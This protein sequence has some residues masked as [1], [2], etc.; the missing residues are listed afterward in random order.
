MSPLTGLKNMSWLGALRERRTPS[1]YAAG[2]LPPRGYR[3]GSYGSG[4]TD[5]AR[6]QSSCAFRNTFLWAR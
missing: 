6:Q 3:C 1:A 2:R 5:A 4:V